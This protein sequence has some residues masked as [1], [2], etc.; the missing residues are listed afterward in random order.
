MKSSNF[1]KGAR[2]VLN[3][4]YFKKGSANKAKLSKLIKYLG[5]REGVQITD[6]V[7]EE[8]KHL[9]PT[10]KQLKLIKT[11][12]QE[13]GVG[14][15]LHEFEDFAKSQNRETASMYISAIMDNNLDKVLSK[16]NLVEYMGKRPGAD[17]DNFLGHGLFCIS[18]NGV[19]T[20]DV[21]I[22]SVIEE[23]GNHP[24][25]VWTNV[26]S[27]RREDAVLTGFE[28]R[29]RWAKMFRSKV[30]SI[31]KEMGI[32][33]ANLKAY[34]A[35][36]DEGHHPH[37]HF[38]VYSGNPGQECLYKDGIERL[39]SEFA[40]GIFTQLMLDIEI[41]KSL[42]RDDLRK[43]AKDEIIKLS[44]TLASKGFAVTT[45]LEMRLVNLAKKL[46]LKGKKV[47]QLL[48]SDVKPDV[49]ELVDLLAKEPEIADLYEK[50]KAHQAELSRF[51]KEDVSFPKLS[52]NDTFRP[53]LNAVVKEAWLIRQWLDS[54]LDSNQT[55]RRFHSDFDVKVYRSEVERP[56]KKAYSNILNELSQCFSGNM[57]A[58]APTEHFDSTMDKKYQE[59]QNAL[60]R[61]LG[62]K[63]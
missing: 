53:V 40:H 36:H 5:T 37:C 46:P 17:K 4:R 63:M 51:Y 60:K 14:Y 26:L 55:S 52:E 57:S 13:Y 42:V 34:G 32:P 27:I 33:I 49:I 59:E 21:D 16:K 11:L 18:D 20:K 38:I 43:T 61:R 54:S 30:L 62:L 1:A 31:S 44:E 29:E 48:P 7:K 8:T 9:L 58:N 35:F 19:V 23:V 6:S 28:D 25:R 12:E 15:G 56:V 24:G 22:E 47:F 45:E 10:E 2:V 3:C 50:W 41:D 39:K